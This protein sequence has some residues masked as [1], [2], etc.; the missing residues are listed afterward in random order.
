MYLTAVL[1]APVLTGTTLTKTLRIMKLLAIMLLAAC[2]QV[3]AKGYSQLI[4][5]SGKNVLAGKSFQKN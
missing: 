1:K 4:T 2:I 5:F 3:S